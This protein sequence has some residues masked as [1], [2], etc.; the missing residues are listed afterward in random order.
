MAMTN[1]ESQWLASAFRTI[2]QI[3]LIEPSNAV[4][5]AVNKDPADQALD[6]TLALI[7]L[8]NDIEGNLRARGVEP[9]GAL[10]IALTTETAWSPDLHG[11]GYF[12]W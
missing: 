3:A 6:A 8:L 10:V 2:A 4:D 12:S 11:R 9:R 1:S 5:S 7:R